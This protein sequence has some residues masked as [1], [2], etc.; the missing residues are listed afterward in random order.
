MYVL[1]DFVSIFIAYQTFV[2]WFSAF[3]SLS[4]G[5]STFLAVDIEEKAI[6]SVDPVIIYPP[7]GVRNIVFT[8]SLPVDGYV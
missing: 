8:D 2:L 6:N 7:D 3:G 1:I 4:F 5:Y